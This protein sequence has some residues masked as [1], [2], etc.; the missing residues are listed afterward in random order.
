MK[1]SHYLRLDP[2]ELPQEEH[3]A[4]WQ[5]GLGRDASVRSLSPI[6]WELL[7]DFEVWQVPDAVITTAYLS[8]FEYQRRRSTEPQHTL[9]LVICL[10]G[11]MTLIYNHEVIARASER[12]ILLGAADLDLTVVAEKPVQYTVIYLNQSA[13]LAASTISDVLPVIEIA[14]TQG[15]WEVVVGAVQQMQVALR[16]RDDL[17]ARALF[18]ALES[19]ID[20]LTKPHFTARERVDGDRVMAIAAFIDEHVRH[21]DLGVDMLCE[22]FHMSRATLYRQ[23]QHVGG[24]KRYMQARRL[25]R[26]FDEM[27]KNP[28]LESGYLR[29]LV[30]SYH[31]R[32][33]GDF[34]SRYQQYF[35]VDPVLLLRARH[36]EQGGGTEG[37]GQD[38][39]FQEPIVQDPILKIPPVVD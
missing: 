21:A 7:G 22:R 2:T 39:G 28:D 13:I 24:V 30:R 38:P 34:S 23:M 36:L 1:V 35:G 32:S 19:A 26:C 14:M 16:R 3:F 6:T 10:K 4:H 18:R 25:A 15:L 37:D 8:P 5:A 17:G 9:A 31:F 27:R 29:A 11:E 20:E 33:F 12:N